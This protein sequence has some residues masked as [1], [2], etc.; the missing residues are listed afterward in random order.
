VFPGFPVHHG[1][2]T[3]TGLLIG[4]DERIIAHTFDGTRHRG[5][6]GSVFYRPNNTNNT[7]H[8]SI[9]LVFAE[10]EIYWK[11]QVLFLD[12]DG[13]MTS[14]ALNEE[15]NTNKSAYPFSRECVKALNELLK[16]HSLRIVLTSSWRTIFN[17]ERQ[18]EVFRDNGVTQTPY[19]QTVDLGYEN[20]SDEIREYLDRKKKVRGFVILD[21]MEIEGFDENYVRIDMNTGL[22]LEHLK[23]VD[24]IL[25]PK[26]E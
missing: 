4:K 2:P 22:T 1:P 10:T 8:V 26:N 17:V 19:D 16:A 24:R 11:M 23:E 14:N 3:S 9:P 21:D 18:C 6:E 5:K 12:I 25:S 20:R 13:V 15:I 7:G